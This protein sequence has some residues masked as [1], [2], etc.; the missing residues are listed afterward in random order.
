[1]AVLFFVCTLGLTFLGS[2]RPKESAGL[3]GS[4]PVSAPAAA[5]SAAS[6]AGAGQDVP[7]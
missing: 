5:A 3:L 1:L 7:K 4:A 2:Y 6:A